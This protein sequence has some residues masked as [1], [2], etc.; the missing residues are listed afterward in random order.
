MI[1]QKTFNRILAVGAVLLAVLLLVSHGYNDIIV[2]T[3]HGINFWDILLDG[4]FFAFY[5]LNRCESG[6]WVYAKAQ[7]CAY[8]ILVYVIFALWNLPLYLL[9]RFAGLDVMNTVPCLIYA[10]LL[11]VAAMAVTVVIVKKILETMDVPQEQHNF[12]LYLYGSSA[13]VM[14]VIFLYAICYKKCYYFSIILNKNYISATI[15][16]IQEF[17]LRR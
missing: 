2:T 4:D 9:E 14:S 17:F 6:N 12:L 8:N 11:P 13:M 5:E 7:G 10:K 16:S 15:S 1:K 3:R